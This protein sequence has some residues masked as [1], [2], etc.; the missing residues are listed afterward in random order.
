M[1]CRYCNSEDLSWKKV[2]NAWYLHNP[3][4]TRHDC[5]KFQS[6]EDPFVKALKDRYNTVRKE[7]ESCEDMSFEYSHTFHLYLDALEVL[8][9]ADTGEPKTNAYY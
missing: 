7:M 1:K 8:I 4:G 2:F 9:T 3:D 5:R 6:I